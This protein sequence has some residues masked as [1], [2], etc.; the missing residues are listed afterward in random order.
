MSW[1]RPWPDRSHAPPI[2][3]RSPG[4]RDLR[5]CSDDRSRRRSRDRDRD[6]GAARHRRAPRAVARGDRT[7]ARF[8][9]RGHGR[10]ARSP[11]RRRGGP[12]VRRVRRAA[13][14]RDRALRAISRRHLGRQG[15]REMG[16]RSPLRDRRRRSRATRPE[17]ARVHRHRSR[18]RALA[19]RLAAH[20]APRAGHR[21]RTGGHRAVPRAASASARF[22]SR[23]GASSTA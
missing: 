12:L 23:C 3:R 10:A 2:C 13:P 15:L 11:Q 8:G 18:R 16:R 14:A 6:P 21:K 17:R 19:R 22:G 20:R 5:T 4:R 1:A 9:H 7:Q